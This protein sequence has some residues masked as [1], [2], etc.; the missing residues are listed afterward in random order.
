MTS[1]S[2]RKWRDDGDGVIMLDHICDRC[3]I[4]KGNFMYYNMPESNPVSLISEDSEP[5]CDLMTVKRI[6][7]T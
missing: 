5:D 2:W 3:G 6:M 7:A 4:V 1:H